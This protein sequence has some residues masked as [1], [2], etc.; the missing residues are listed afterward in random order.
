MASCMSSSLSAV[1]RQM[2]KGGML[3]IVVIIVALFHE[4]PASAQVNLPIQNIQQ[5]TASWCWVAVA[6]QIIRW[7]NN[8]RGPQQ[9]ELVAIANGLP[10]GACCFPSPNPMVMQACMRTGGLHEI[11]GMIAAFGHSFSVVAPPTHP[12][13]LFQTLQQ[14]HPIIL[15]V[16]SSP[17]SGHVV[18]LRGMIMGPD[19]LLII[20]D[21]MGWT[22]FSQPVPFSRLATMWQAAILVQ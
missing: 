21:P 5:R 6:E 18:V 14:G 1:L 2:L 20:N 10:P 16:Q 13:A 11:Q 17:F 9:C 4:S 3:M 8:G 22:G 19:P 7:K 15:A 12:V